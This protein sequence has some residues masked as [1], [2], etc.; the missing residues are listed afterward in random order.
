MADEVKALWGQYLRNL[1][2]HPLRTKVSLTTLLARSLDRPLQLECWQEVLTW[3]L[4][5]WPE[6]ET[7]SSSVLF[8]SWC[9]LLIGVSGFAALRFLLFGSVWTLFPQVYGETHSFSSRQQDDSQ[10]GRPWKS[11]KIQLKSNFPSVQLNAW[12]FW[13][14]VSL[15]NYKYL[16]IQLRVL[17]QNLAAV[18]WGIFLILRSKA[19]VPKLATA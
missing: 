3:L 11:V 17:F 15:I 8:F 5:S 1:Q 4:R 7:Y 6:R 16:P 12:R 2:R 14:I 10:Q 13:P 9:F 19:S 18:C